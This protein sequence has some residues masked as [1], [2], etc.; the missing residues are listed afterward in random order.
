MFCSNI[1]HLKILGEKKKE[2]IIYTEPLT[3][4]RWPIMFYCYR[5]YLNSCTNTAITQQVY[6]TT[7]NNTS[8]CRS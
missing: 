3:I 6:N 4:A 7:H 5:A 1:Y 2:K 8:H